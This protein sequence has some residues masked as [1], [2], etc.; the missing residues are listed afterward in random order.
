M[1]ELFSA[2]RETQKWKDL[3]HNYVEKTLGIYKT[4]KE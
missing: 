2:Q 1:S 3:Q 4:E